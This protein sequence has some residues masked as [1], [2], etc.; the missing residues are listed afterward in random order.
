MVACRGCHSRLELPVGTSGY[1][2]P[3][4]LAGKV[5]KVVNHRYPTSKA[6]ELT[7]LL[8]K[9]LTTLES[10]CELFEAD[11]ASGV[12][13]AQGYLIEQKKP[14]KEEEN[15]KDTKS[16]A[17]AESVAG[18]HPGKE[19]PSAGPSMAVK[20]ESEGNEGT[21]KSKSSRARSTSRHR[22]RRRSR[23]RRRESKKTRGSPSPVV[24]E[25]QAEVVGTEP[26]DNEDF[27]ELEGEEEEP[28]RS[29]IDDE[30]EQ[31]PK[32]F[33]LRQT[34]KPSSRK[35]LPRRPRAPSVSPPG[36]HSR[37]PAPL[38]RWKGWQH[39][40]RG[41]QR[42]AKGKGKGG[43]AA[44]L[45][46]SHGAEG[47]GQQ[48]RRRYEQYYADQQHT[49]ATRQIGAGK[50]WMAG[51][52]QSDPWRTGKKQRITAIHVSSAAKSSKST[53]THREGTSSSSSSAR[54]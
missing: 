20:E 48:G 51:S 53:G 19:H 49:C 22:R 5:T 2:D 40:Y 6:K 25:E 24:V 37:D 50:P 36:Y 18:E 9:V 43:R 11:R 8:A 23:S 14:V 12:V 31:N 4:Y 42:Q 28:P 16:S 41:Q 34:A 26:E 27:E 17:K 10:D 52:W 30:V 54:I 39:V 35:P 15:K 47:D 7:H 29:R 13:D 44:P 46:G 33:E 1:C 3:C 38:K 21:R 45:K 32:K